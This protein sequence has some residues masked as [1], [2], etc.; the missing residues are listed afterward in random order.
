VHHQLANADGISF[1]IRAAAQGKHQYDR[2]HH[3]HGLFHGCF[4]QQKYISPSFRMTEAK[5]K[6]LY[7]SIQGR[8]YRGT[9]LLCLCLAAYASSG[10]APDEKISQAEKS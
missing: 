1:C 8:L 9:T 6:S 3:G 2:Q 5:E 7:F 4:L 10:F